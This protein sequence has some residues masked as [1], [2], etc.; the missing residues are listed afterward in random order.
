[1]ITFPPPI[2]LVV[3]PHVVSPLIST[4]IVLEATMKEGSGLT[5]L[6]CLALVYFGPHL[7]LAL[8]CLASLVL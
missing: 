2:G 8:S 3:L 1:M 5:S 6:A 7:C 4:G